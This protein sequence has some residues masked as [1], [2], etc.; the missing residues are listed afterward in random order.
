[1][2]GTV[3]VFSCT[4]QAGYG[5]WG[6]NATALRYSGSTFHKKSNSLRILSLSF[7]FDFSAAISVAKNFKRTE[8]SNC[9]VFK[10]G[11]GV[12]RLADRRI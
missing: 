12:N 7:I 9:G 6:Q 2:C 8:L 4:I 10:G 3:D 11:G 1:M 5:G